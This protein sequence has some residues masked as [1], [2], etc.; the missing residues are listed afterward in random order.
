M[1][2]EAEGGTG[3]VY[4]DKDPPPAY[5][6]NNPQGTFKQ[7]LRDLELWQACTDV[8][9]EKQGLKLVQVLTHTA[10]AAVDS[11]EVKDIK[12][13]TGYTNVVAKLKE[14]FEPYTETALPRAMEAAFFGPPRSAKET[15][16]DYLVRFQKAQ[17]ALKAEGVTLP[18]KAEG[19]LLYRQSNLTAEDDSKLLTWLAGD[20]DVA[21]VTRNLRKL[22]RVKADGK[23]IYFGEPAGD[24][25]LDGEPAA[26][27]Y[28]DAGQPE[29]E[30]DDEDD[31][32]FVYIQ[33][34]ELDQV[35]DEDEV[36]DAL[37]SYQQVRQQ[38]K[39]QR[40]GRGFFPKGRPADQ[41]GKSSGKGKF[42]KH[43]KG[44]GQR[45]LH[46]EELKLRTRCRTCGQVGHWSKECRQGRSEQPSSTGQRPPGS[47][48]SGSPS[49]ASSFYWNSGA[50]A[51]SGASFFTFGEA[52]RATQ[53]KGRADVAPFIGIVTNES[54]ALVDTAA[55]EG[56]IGR[57]ALLRLCGALRNHHLQ[58]H[59]VDKQSCARGI[60]GQ[61]RTIGVCEIPLGIGGTPGVLEATVVSD[62][63]PLL[64]PISLL[65]A[66]GSVID[67]PSNVLRLTFVNSEAPMTTLPS[68]HAAVSIV[69]FGSCGWQ[70]PEACLGKRK[71]TDFRV[72]TSS[73]SRGSLNSMV[74][75]TFRSPAHV[76]VAGPPSARWRSKAA[77][78]WRVVCD[79]LWCL[80]QWGHFH[81]TVSQWLSTPLPSATT[82]S[83]AAPA[84]SSGAGPVVL[85]ATQKAQ[86]Y[87]RYLEKGPERM[88][89]V[90]GVP[91]VAME[92]CTHPAQELKGGGN[93]HCNWVHCAACH[94]RWKLSPRSAA[95]VRHWAEQMASAPTAWNGK[96]TAG[97]MELDI[98][99]EREGQLLQTIA[100]QRYRLEQMEAQMDLM[101]GELA[102]E[103]EIAEDANHALELTM[104]EM[105]F[106]GKAQTMEVLARYRQRKQLE[107]E[108]RAKSNSFPTRE[109][110]AE[111][112]QA[113]QALKEAAAQLNA[114]HQ[115]VLQQRA[116]VAVL[117]QATPKIIKQW[118]RGPSAGL[119]DYVAVE[120][121]GNLERRDRW[122]MQRDAGKAPGKAYAVLKEIPLL[123]LHEETETAEN[124]AAGEEQ[125]QLLQQGI[126]ALV[127]P[128]EADQMQVWTANF[129]Q[130][131]ADRWALWEAR[132]PKVLRAILDEHPGNVNDPGMDG[133]AAGCTCIFFGA[134]ALPQRRLVT[135]VSDCHRY[136]MANRGGELRGDEGLDR[137]Y[138]DGGPES[139][140][141]DL[142]NIEAI[143]EDEEEQPAEAPEAPPS[144]AGPRAQRPLQ[145]NEPT[146][147]EKAR[148]QKLHQNL[149]HPDSATIARVLRVGGAPDYLWRWAK[150]SFRCP[151]C[152]A[153]PMPKAVRPALVPKN[154]A[155]NV[156]V[157]VDLMHI[158]SWDG[159]S[160]EWYLNVIDLGTSY[161]AVEKVKDKQPNSAWHGF[162]RAWTRHFGMPQIV[163]ADQGTEFLGLFRERCFQSGTI[164]H[165]IG[166][167]SPHQ[168]GRAERHGGLFKMMLEKARH[169]NPPASSEELKL[170]VREVEAAKNR[171]SDRSGFSP[172]QRMLGQNARVTG[173]LL[174]DTFI[175]PTLGE[176][177][178][179]MEK[180]MTAR[181]AAQRAFVDVNTSEAAKRA[182]RARAR[183]QRRFSPGDVVFLWRSWRTQGQR[184][185][186]W[187]GPAVVLMRLRR[188]LWN[189][190]RIEDP[191]P[192]VPVPLPPVPE[193]DIPEEPPVPEPPV[194]E[195][196]FPQEPVAAQERQQSAI[197]SEEPEVEHRASHPLSREER[198]QAGVEAVERNQRLDGAVPMAQ[199]AVM[200]R[201]GEGYRAIR[202]NQRGEEAAHPYQRPA[203]DFFEEEPV[204][205]E[206]A[207]IGNPPAQ[208]DRWELLVDRGIVRRHH[209]KWRS[210]LFSPWEAS[211]MPVPVAALT[212]ERRTVHRHK[213]GDQVEAED[214]WKS[215]APKREHRATR[216]WKGY[217][218]FY[219][220]RKAAKEIK[221]T[222]PEQSQDSGVYYTFETIAKENYLVK[223]AASDEVK[224]KDI[225]QEEWPLWQEED[226][227]EWNKILASNAVRVLS[228][229]ESE[230]VR[231]QLAAEGK[232]DRII[233][234]RFVRRRKPSEV[235]GEAPSLKSR[236]CVRGDQDPDSGELE[237]YAPTVNTQNL[238]VI[239]QLAASHK[240]KGTCGDLK[241]AFTQSNPLLRVQ[242]KLYFRQPRG[243]L[244][245]M[246]PG[247]LVEIVAGVYGLIGG[248]AHWRKTLTGFITKDLGYRQSRLDPTVYKLFCGGSLEGLINIEVDDLLCFGGQ[249]HA[250]RLARLRERFHFGKFKDLSEGTMFNGR[251]LQQYP[252]GKITVSMEKFILER[253]SPM[254]IAVGRRSRPE[255]AANEV[256]KSAAR[257]L[258][259]SIAWAAKEG[260]PDLAATASI[261]ASKLSKLQ[262]KDLTLL[263]KAVQE[264]KANAKLEL[265]YHPIAPERLCWGTATDASYVNHPDGS[266]QGAVVILAFDQDLLDGCVASCSLVW[267]KSGKLRRKINSTLA[268]ET[269]S[270]LKGLG[271]LMWA[272][273]IYYELLQE[274][275][276]LVEFKESVKRKA[277]LVLQR[278]D[279]DDEL[280]WALSIVDAKSL[281]DH[282]T[283]DGS[284]AQDK[285]TALD[286]SI[287]R[288]RIDGLG[289]RVRWVEHQ[290]MIADCL[291]KVGA[292]K[293]AML[294]LLQ[295]GT[296]R[297]V[298][299]EERMID[300]KERRD[301]G[302]VKPR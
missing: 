46:I 219:L 181:R 106:E 218:E 33:E 108:T 284:Q 24:G 170:L 22:E 158:P 199:R 270:L 147:E 165:T 72:N 18:K 50:A 146:A 187:V 196:P 177:G 237:A 48:S 221:E 1:T 123:L 247:Q 102:A 198:V 301:Q 191:E 78:N 298:A 174:S 100:D 211:R 23:G 127:S 262:V 101:H 179:E 248:P 231:V 44:S 140:P 257:G 302:R 12:G 224:E 134:P 255:E 259:G 129:D 2:Q 265:T 220:T 254:T 175:D 45:R 249:E 205:E 142:S 200:G 75:A 225:S 272:K 125:H 160:M 11:M 234:S 206:P 53:E 139:Y 293:T 279:S 297:L 66:L 15:V 208:R 94:A 19:Y 62:D 110:R 252:D 126:H 145:V 65:R 183:T 133:S 235:V 95:Q 3:W 88:A 277:E 64:I 162:T 287:A 43:G 42:D 124:D 149:G 299:E 138:Q 212:S 10:K 32:Q 109:T 239:L 34:G 17:T 264:A 4:R 57:P 194:P 182:L 204:L 261:M 67:L 144:G 288:E 117:K 189:R 227:A 79:K 240:L 89:N 92:D 13:E 6:G 164:V 152:Q 40:K 244:P 291:T 163:L 166:A 285:F 151:A 193:D 282:L 184:K 104:T 59:W 31:D 37:A 185:S 159:Q 8:P 25:S 268:A 30:D 230:K 216:K 74:A 143:E 251:F 80:V 118:L 290:S 238:Q 85:A 217:T 223:K 131:A 7:Y 168:N 180:T 135:N 233:D 41:K 121:D 215:L 97:P 5:S 70:F 274:N 207:K 35:L 105:S 155:P 300:R 116:S 167:R 178:D 271:D 275:F 154:Y 157:A 119:E 294:Q 98:D 197:S 38:L 130:S 73:G 156:V 169:M 232:L 113:V 61:A 55:Q 176:M 115:S 203:D 286:V 103:V 260:R 54:Q 83:I 278:A 229:E 93:G 253:L 21:V 141:I 51:S 114:Y 269:Q 242:G 266:S 71:E 273:A 153:N 246:L 228:P 120:V 236:F 150:Q 9:K 148:V 173:E 84:G 209:V 63:V 58:I 186:G 267:W 99:P 276:D 296:Y 132:R 172:A 190:V 241:A 82:P 52:L 214:D 29:E 77:R 36:M 256:E 289:V 81:T 202:E 226:A 49:K 222:M 20:F 192:P 122:D 96:R 128:K 69:D 68:G 27:V 258:I 188:M 243:G 86:F 39:D 28:Y 281:Y 213:D 111:W 91:L 245:N 161:Q 263:N 16:A 171:L 280:R 283:R 76:S 210:H 47:S 90:K 56:L 87:K 136:R 201:E 295:K 26:E 14:A 137:N 195:V 107:L 112:H 292:N 60:G 250:M